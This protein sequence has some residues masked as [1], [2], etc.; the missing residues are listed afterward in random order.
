ML[1]LLSLLLQSVSPGY[2]E[3][4][5]ATEEVL[6][7]LSI[8]ADYAFTSM[9]NSKEEQR[10]SAGQYVGIACG[11]GWISMHGCSLEK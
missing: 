1:L 2:N 5:W 3:P 10:L 6:K 8:L 9:Y 7:N 4:S 11:S